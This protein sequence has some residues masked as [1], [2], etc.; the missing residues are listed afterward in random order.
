MTTVYTYVCEDCHAGWEFTC[1]E[2]DWF[3]RDETHCRWCG[4][5][6]VVRGA[7]TKVPLENESENPVL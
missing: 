6:G 1:N 3:P 4:N 5:R 2:G 7:Y